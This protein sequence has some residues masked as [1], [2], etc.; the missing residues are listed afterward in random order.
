MIAHLRWVLPLLCCAGAAT[1]A[2]ASTAAAPPP[3]DAARVWAAFDRAG[4]RASDASGLADRRTG[5]SVTADDAARIASVSKLAVALGVMRLVEA[6]RLDLDEDVS[7]RLGWPL[8]HPGFPDQPVTLRALLSHTAGIRDGIDYALP[9]DADLE[10]EM[11]RPEAWDAAHGPAAGFY[12]YSNLNF[13]VIAAVME[14]ATGKRFDVLMKEEVFAPLGIDACFNWTTCS[15]DAVARGVV[16]YDGEGQAL[17]DDNGG[18]RPACGAIP[19]RDGSCDVATYR[20][21]RQGA[22]FSPQGGMRIS[23]KGLAR[24]GQLLLGAVP[25]YLPAARIAEMMQPQWRYDGR[26]GDIENGYPC[27]LGLGVMIL[28][29]PDQLAVCRDD[30]FGDGR[31]RIGHSGE[32]YGLRSGLWVDPQGGEGVSFF[33]TA[34]PADTPRGRTAFTLAE[35]DM[36]ARAR[37]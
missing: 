35:E 27:A 3:A 1:A 11:R 4:I 25:E 26:N 18:V 29:L 10:S 5:R 6:G 23:V 30:P 33:V 14:A 24:I 17:R 36:I 8:R 15:D 20:L 28:A 34:L 37:R 13:P 31:T 19:A 9:L 7:V 22:F 12:T 21:G 2:M 16:L 32:A